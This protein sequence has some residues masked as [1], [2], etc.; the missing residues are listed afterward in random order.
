MGFERYYGFIGGETDQWSPLLVRDNHM[1]EEEREEG[2]H[3]TADLVDQTI[4]HIRDQQQ[5]NTGRP[6]FAYLAL[7]AA[8]AP[9]HAP[10]E[11]IGKYRKAFV[12]ERLIPIGSATIFQ[13]SSRR[14]WRSST[15]LAAPPPIRTIQWAGQWQATR[16]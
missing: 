13:T 10:K 7:A 8:H 5:A 11:Y 4:S 3:L 15:N 1:I 12:T 16:R 9:L 6:F 14:C 2:Y